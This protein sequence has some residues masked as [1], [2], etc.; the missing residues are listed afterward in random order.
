MNIC[1][2]CR[3]GYIEPNDD[4]YYCE[5][6]DDVFKMKS[7]CGWWACK[8]GMIGTPLE[9]EHDFREI[10]KRKTI[11]ALKSCMAD[12]K[13]RDCP[14]EKC[15]SFEEKKREVPVSL[16]QTVLALLEGGAIPK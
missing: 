12:P 10:T 15:E 1:E 16:L 8:L 7:I 2:S 14:W 5:A 6:Y 9:H 13:C 11:E 3:F 4:G